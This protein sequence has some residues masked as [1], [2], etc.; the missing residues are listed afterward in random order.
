MNAAIVGKASPTATT[1]TNLEIGMGY[2]PLGRLPY[3]RGFALRL[4]KA[5]LRLRLMSWQTA[6]IGSVLS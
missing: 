1:K 5:T 6:L 4:Q 2:P 3:G